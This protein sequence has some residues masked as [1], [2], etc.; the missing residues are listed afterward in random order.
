MLLCN[1]C[2]AANQL[3]PL[4]TNTTYRVKRADSDSSSSS[5]DDSPVTPTSAITLSGRSGRAHSSSLTTFRLGSS[6]SSSISED[7]SQSSDSG[8]A[9]AK[10]DFEPVFTSLPSRRA[11]SSGALALAPTTGM[12]GLSSPENASPVSPSFQRRTPSFPVSRPL[13]PFDSISNAMGTNPKRVSPTTEAPFVTKIQQE[14]LQTAQRIV[15]DQSR[16]SETKP[17]PWRSNKLLEPP[18]NSR[19]QGGF[20]ILDMTQDEFKSRAW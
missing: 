17:K 4:Q 12:S 9:T 14:K 5:A 2:R 19:F 16:V 15:S 7:D 8:D 1:F 11:K 18:K 20:F 10:D 3:T 13:R 6:S